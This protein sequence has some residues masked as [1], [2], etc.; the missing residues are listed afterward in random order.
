ML[1][2][3]GSHFTKKRPEQTFGAKNKQA[4][5]GLRAFFHPDCY[6]RYRSYTG[7]CAIGARGLYRR[8][9]IA[10]CPEDMLRP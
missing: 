1:S 6:G 3:R 9:G 4:K 10:P 8:S 2:R 7:S 5:N